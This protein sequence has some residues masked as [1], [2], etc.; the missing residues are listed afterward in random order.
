MKQTNVP[1]EMS[2]ST[3]NNCS[4]AEKSSVAASSTAEMVAFWILTRKFCRWKEKLV[5]NI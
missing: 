3:V 5:I 2:K 4:L 1:F